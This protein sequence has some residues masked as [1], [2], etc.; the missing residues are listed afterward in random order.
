MTAQRERLLFA[1][2]SADQRLYRAQL[3]G[4]VLSVNVA[5]PLCVQ[6]CIR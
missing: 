2:G 4:G 1:L 6:G 5:E 3:A